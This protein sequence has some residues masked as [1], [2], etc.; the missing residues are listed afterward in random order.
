MKKTVLVA[1]LLTVISAVSFA[2]ISELGNT[3]KFQVVKNQD[4]KYDLYYVSENNNDV[5]VR[6]KD[7]KGKVVNY[8]RIEDVKAFKR[9]YN[10]KDLPAGNYTL[11]VK[12]NEGRAT[13]S[14]FHNPQ[15]T[16]ELHSL[17]G[18]L[19]DENR[20]KVLVGPSESI[21]PIEVKIYD[22]SGKVVLKETIDSNGG[23]SKIYDLSTI[24]GDHVTFYISKGQESASYARDLK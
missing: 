6:I 14:I 21:S 5:F 23:F 12:N 13:Q 2:G 1:V 11:E 18:K 17:V 4:S 8:D 10:F 20:F 7:A 15:G 3:T 24:T 16:N 9:T 19:P 22:Q